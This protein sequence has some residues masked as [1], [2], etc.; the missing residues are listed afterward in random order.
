M[1]SFLL[2]SAFWLFIVVLLLPKEQR[3]VDLAGLQIPRTLGDPHLLIAQQKPILV[4]PESFCDR[5]FD[6]CLATLTAVDD[7]VSLGV[8]TL[9]QLDREIKR[10][11]LPERA[12]QLVRP[13]S[14]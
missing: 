14:E 10:S 2:R 8:D 4:Q 6:L 5:N 11:D 13:R 1:L 12:V 9:E 3:P 7:G